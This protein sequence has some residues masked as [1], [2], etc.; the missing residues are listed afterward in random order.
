MRKFWYNTDDVRVGTTDAN[1]IVTEYENSREGTVTLVTRGDGAETLASVAV[2]HDAAD[3][4]VCDGN[5][6]YTYTY[7]PDGQLA[8]ANY[9]DGG[10][11]GRPLP[12][13]LS[14]FG[15]SLNGTDNSTPT[16]S[17]YASFFTGKPYIEGLGHAF[18]MRNYRASLAK[19]QTA[20]PLGY[21]DGGNALAYGCTSPLFGRFPINM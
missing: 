20:D 5:A 6:T 15:E 4:L 10:R 2:S 21:P 1:G 11:A 14:A 18:F 12:A 16:P 17:T 8:T 7:H 19:W 3:R 13:A 9:G